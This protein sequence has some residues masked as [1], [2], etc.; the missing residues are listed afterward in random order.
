MWN[1]FSKNFMKITHKYISGFR[2][3]VREFDAVFFFDFT[4]YISIHWTNLIDSNASSIRYPCLCVCVDVCAGGIVWWDRKNYNK[5]S[6][7]VVV[8]P[9][10]YMT[11]ISFASRFWK[12]TYILYNIYQTGMLSKINLRVRDNKLK[13]HNTKFSNRL[14]WCWANGDGGSVE[15]NAHLTL[16]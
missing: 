14:D 2:T 1:V 10:V 15:C 7:F 16:T 5:Y 8:L 4:F 6:K 11:T 13:V 3:H 12:L 9:C